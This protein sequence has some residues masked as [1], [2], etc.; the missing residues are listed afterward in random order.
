[1]E[2]IQCQNWPCSQCSGNINLSAVQRTWE[3]R[4]ALVEAPTSLTWLHTGLI[5]ISQLFVLLF[6]FP[7][8]VLWRRMETPHTIKLKELHTRSDFLKVTRVTRFVE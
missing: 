2:M 3:S 6:F 4:G 8:D 1:M 5:V 7:H